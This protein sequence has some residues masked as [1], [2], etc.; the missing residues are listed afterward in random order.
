MKED[1][2]MERPRGSI[3]RDLAE[4]KAE[5]REKHLCLRCYVNAGL[6]IEVKGDACSNCGAVWDTIKK[7]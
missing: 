3:S 1:I 4:L 7:I 5:A 2:K 6:Q